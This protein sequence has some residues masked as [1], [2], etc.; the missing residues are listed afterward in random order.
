MKKYIPH[1][2]Q[3]SLVILGVVTLLL[4]GAEPSSSSEESLSNYYHSTDRGN[5]G[6]YL[7]WTWVVFAVITLITFI[8]LVIDSNKKLTK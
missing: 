3:I 5:F 7:C 2:F 6:W 8:L 4:L 1:L